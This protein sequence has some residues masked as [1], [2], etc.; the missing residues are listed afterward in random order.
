MCAPKGEFDAMADPAARTD[1]PRVTVAGGGLAGLT[2]ALRLAERGYKVTIHEQKDVLGGDLASRPGRD[3]STYLDVYPHM[4]LNWYVN[5]WRLLGDVTDADREQLFRPVAGVKELRRGAF[6]RF[7]E[8]SHPF[9]PRYLLR[10]LFSGMN[11][12]ADMFVFGYAS[13]DL[14]AEQSQSTLDLSNMSVDGF[15]NARPYMTKRAVEAYDTFITNVW[16]IPSYSASAQDYIDYLSYAIAAPEPPF[17]LARGPASVQFIK[18]LVEALERLD[19]KI[20]LKSQATE[21]SC[22]ARRAT[23]I[24][25]QRTQFDEKSDTWRG[26]GKV[27]V[28]DLDELVVAVP[29]EN[30]LNL[31][32]GGESGRRVVEVAPEMADVSR[33]WSQ[34]IP[35]VHLFFTRKLQQ[36]PPEPVGMAD[37]RLSLGFTDIS[38]TWNESPLAEATVLSLSASDP[39]GLPGT[40]WREDAMAMIRELA[41]YLPFDPGTKWKESADIDWERTTYRANLD[42]PLF[43][44][45]V[46]S[47]AWR[48]RAFRHHLVNVAFAGDFC[49]SRIGMTTVE[50]AVTTGLEAARAIVR[51]RGVGEDVPIE[52]P[53]TY[54]G[55]Y[56]VLGRWAYAPYA[57]AAKACSDARDL[58]PRARS[59]LRRLAP[60]GSLGRQR[61]DS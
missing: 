13:I 57:Y 1:P 21:I 26:V 20:N 41:E 3:K 50:S 10:N 5:F 54:W 49:Q 12:V 17:W 52:E 28:E 22:D 47:N 44:N 58:V 36:I 61:P 39:Y 34:P 46:G 15:L 55:G 32:R 4:Y 31:I 27:E 11:P 59:L 18:P 53:E 29:P 60:P 37:S 48:P 7:S 43:V 56:W 6:P 51:E 14:L 19:V 9:T 30:L 45:E 16:A 42:N 8:L 23:S 38:Q 33:L 35:I 2:A 25:F 24:G 40:G